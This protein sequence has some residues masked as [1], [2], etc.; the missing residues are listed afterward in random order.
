MILQDEIAK[1]IVHA[2]EHIN[3][4]GG[5]KSPNTN[6]AIIITSLLWGL[7]SWIGVSL[8]D[9][10]LFMQLICFT[11][12]SISGSITLALLVY[13]NKEDLKKMAKWA[14]RIKK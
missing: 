6:G 1:K 4:F 9:S 8:E 12:G 13:R 7:F 14:L 5:G 10:K 11:I 2:H 3:N